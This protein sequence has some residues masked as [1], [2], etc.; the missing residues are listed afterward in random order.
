VCPGRFHREALDPPARGGAALHL[1]TK[2]RLISQ[3]DVAAMTGDRK[4]DDV[5]CL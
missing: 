2:P 4:T 3:E 1:R 5:R